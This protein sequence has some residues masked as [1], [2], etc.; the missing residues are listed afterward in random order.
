MLNMVLVLVWCMCM[1]HMHCTLNNAANRIKCV[2]KI[3]K[4]LWDLYIS[5]YFLVDWNCFVGF[6]LVH[7]SYFIHL[8]F[9]LLRKKYSSSKFISSRCD[10][11]HSTIRNV[12]LAFDH[13][14]NDDIQCKP[15]NCQAYCIRQMWISCHIN[16]EYLVFHLHTKKSY[17]D[18]FIWITKYLCLTIPALFIWLVGLFVRLLHFFLLLS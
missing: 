8:V 15:H 16:I 7:P 5:M 9:F 6:R 3:D 4:P 1:S 14:C 13:F 11:N 17:R 18:I 12:V 10:A 2:V